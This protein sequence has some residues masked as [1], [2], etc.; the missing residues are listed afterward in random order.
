MRHSV[1]SGVRI[2]GDSVSPL[3]DD[4]DPPRPADHDDLALDA[5]VESHEDWLMHRV[6]AYARQRGYT[7]YSS[8]LAEAW[9]ISIEGVSTALAQL[10]RTDT[11]P[12]EHGPD[13]D[14][15]SDPS[16]AFGILEARL[17]RSRG[18][19]L[20]MFLGM[21]K[22]YRQAYL[23]LLEEAGLPTDAGRAYRLFIERFFDRVEL[24][25]TT[26]WRTIDDVE[27]VSELQ[28]A[29]RTAVNE[30]NR[31]LTL[32]ESLREPVL[33][34]DE[35]RRIVNVNQ[36]AGELLYE[37]GM[38]GHVYYTADVELEV[39]AWLAKE[40]A[41]VPAT[42]VPWVGFEQRM[43]TPS[44]PRHFDVRARR[45]QDVSGK[46]AGWTVML[47]EVTERVEL[48]KRLRFLVTRDHLTGLY[49]RRT[50]PEILTREVSRTQRYG[51]RI[52]ILLVDIRKLGEVNRH[53]GSMAGD[54]VLRSVAKLLVDQLR[55]SDVVIRYG[56]DEFL[57][58]AL[59][60]GPDGVQ[61]AAT[62]IQEAVATWG[63]AHPVES[64]SVTVG[65]GTA[66]WS[67]QEDE[68]I[69]SAIGRATD[70]LEHH[71]EL[72]GSGPAS[73]RSGEGSD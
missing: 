38:A 56:D 63:E 2:S 25:F 4:R 61:S 58:L 37:P 60:T 6:L 36:A 42:G 68:R 27:R 28:A 29:N 18:I 39:P 65:V 41:A 22:Y 71:A 8:T 62:R 43:D 59:E 40:L 11:T 46:F 69:E 24:G 49:N 23:D 12:P 31:Y 3:S 44:G 47:H 52:G 9:R 54:R 53:A 30:K 67:P 26:E 17:H 10:Y 5:L 57:V 7:R 73:P 55:A 32:F 72:P 34:L 14:F 15:T 19:N 33:L 70:A 50:L 1:G 64:I 16:A 45:M 20:G 66:V 13:D 48:A 21:M 51:Q 35:K